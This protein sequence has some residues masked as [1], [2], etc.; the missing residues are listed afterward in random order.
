MRNAEQKECPSYGELA[1]DLA[2]PFQE[3]QHKCGWRLEHFVVDLLLNC[4]TG[5][6]TDIRDDEGLYRVFNRRTGPIQAAISITI[7]A[8]ADFDWAIEPD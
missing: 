7:D 2:D 1:D 3:K 5:R 6:I 8:P 4:K